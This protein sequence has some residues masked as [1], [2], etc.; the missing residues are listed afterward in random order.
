ML[1][2]GVCWMVW[3]PLLPLHRDAIGMLLRLPAYSWHTHNYV[4]AAWSCIHTYVIIRI[5]YTSIHT[6][7]VLARIYSNVRS[8]G[9][10]VHTARDSINMFECLCPTPSLPEHQVQ[11]ELQRFCPTPP[12]ISIP[13]GGR[14][15]LDPIGLLYHSK[16][17]TCPEWLRSFIGSYWV[18]PFGKKP[19]YITSTPPTQFWSLYRISNK[20]LVLDFDCVMIS[21]LAGEKSANVCSKIPVSKPHWQKVCLFVQNMAYLNLI[22]I[23]KGVTRWEVSG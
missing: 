20:F 17:E 15:L 6:H 10:A 12:Y 23:D 8:S 16:L 18:K 13:K 14:S 7:L 19:P 5:P 4:H 21:H 2:Y 9:Q 3:G 1:S 11:M 22:V